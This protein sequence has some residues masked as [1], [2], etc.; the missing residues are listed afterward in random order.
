[1]EHC[2]YVVTKTKK[3]DVLGM[4][5]KENYYLKKALD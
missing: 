2:T 3:T 1:M 5:E 4:R